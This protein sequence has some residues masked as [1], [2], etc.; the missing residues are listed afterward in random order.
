M[1][2]AFPLDRIIIVLLYVIQTHVK[3]CTNCAAEDHG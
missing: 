1:E 3:I 2:S